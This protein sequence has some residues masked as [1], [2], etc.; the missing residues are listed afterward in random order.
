MKL[1]ST[2]ILAF[3]EVV[4]S[5]LNQWLHLEFVEKVNRVQTLEF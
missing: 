2:F 4:L 3:L 5:Y 1:E